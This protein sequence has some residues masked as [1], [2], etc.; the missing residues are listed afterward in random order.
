MAIGF[1]IFKSKNN[2][3]NRYNTKEVNWQNAFARK[4]ILMKTIKEIIEKLQTTDEP[5]LWMD[6]LVRDSRAGVKNA[7]VRWKR[8][9]DKRELIKNE[10][11]SKITFDQS[12]AP[13]DG[14]LIAGVDE[15]GRGPLAG[16]VVTAAVI[17]PEE[18]ENLLGWTIRKRF[19]KPIGN[20]LL[21]KSGCIAIDYSVH[22]QPASENR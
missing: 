1:F 13:F 19:Q 10:H 4:V 15:A 16:P 5:E 14:A 17:L 21:K 11:E 9:Y 2:F 20:F 12:F 3:R 18:T 22:I 7:L 6:K 8:Q